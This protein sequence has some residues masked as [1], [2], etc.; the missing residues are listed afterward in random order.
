MNVGGREEYVNARAGRPLQR[1]PGTLDIFFAGAGQRGD[2]G[3]PN[4]RGHRLHGVKIAVRGD[5]E[6]GFQTSTPRRSSCCPRRSFSS[7]FML[8]PGDCSPSRSVVS[9]MVMRAGAIR[10]KSSNQIFYL[11]VDRAS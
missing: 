1:L 6:A 7:T 10:S 9:K 2:D 8:Q 11:T 5:G 4:G 3:A